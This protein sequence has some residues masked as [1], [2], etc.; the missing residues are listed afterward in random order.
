MSRTPGPAWANGLTEI[1]MN[2]NFIYDRFCHWINQNHTHTHK[3]L[4]EEQ[5][6]I[7]SLHFQFFIL[8][9]FLL[10]T[11]LAV[12]IKVAQFLKSNSIEMSISDWM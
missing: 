3:N 5:K 1:N 6:Q 7:R 11:Y 9:S 12:N 4:F 2:T 8:S 10:T